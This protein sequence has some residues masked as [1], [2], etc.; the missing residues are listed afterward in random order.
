MNCTEIWPLLRS[1]RVA[2]LIG[3]LLRERR[4]LVGITQ[5][6]AAHRLGWHREVYSRF[7]RGLHVQSL[8]QLRHA[9]EMLGTHPLWVFNR[10][11][12]VRWFA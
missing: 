3:R 12:R 9:C 7:E 8:K 1:E 4:E 5:A 2:R 10:L 6:E 11:D